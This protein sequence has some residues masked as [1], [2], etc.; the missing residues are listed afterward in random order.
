LPLGDLHETIS[1]IGK[2]MLVSL[3]I[4]TVTKMYLP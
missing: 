3:E 2:R 4:D 1:R